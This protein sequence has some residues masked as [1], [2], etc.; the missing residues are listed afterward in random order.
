M[1]KVVAP[2][3]VFSLVSWA[4][5]AGAEA[6]IKYEN[7]VWRQDAPDPT[8]WEADGKYYAAS[9]HQDILESGDLVH[10]RKSG[11]RLLED[12]EYAWIAKTWPHV[13]APQVRKIG[14]GYNLYISFHNGGE[15]TAIAVYRSSNP[16]GPF[17]DRRILVRS[18]TDGQVE[19][20]DPEVA[21]DTDGRLWLFFGHGDVRRVELSAD[22]L[23]RKPGS[24]I[25][26]VAGIEWAS[27]GERK[28]YSP[29]CST[30]GAYLHRH[31]GKWYLFVSE[32]GWSDHTY[33]LSVG[34]ADTLD[35][36]FLDKAGRPMRDGH[37]T[38]ILQSEKNDDFFG[39]GHNGEIM[40]LPSGRT[41]VFYH[42]HWRNEQDTKDA[43]RVRS[44]SGYVPRPLFLQEIFWDADG[45]PYFENGGKPQKENV[46]RFAKTAVHPNSAALT[47]FHTGMTFGFGCPAGYFATP[48]AKAEVDHMYADGVRWV[49]LVA[50]V[51][52]EAADSPRQYAESTLTPG[53]DELAEIIA[54]MHRR[55]MRVQLRPMLECFDG[56]TRAKVQIREDAAGTDN[57]HEK[58]SAWFKGLA[59][60]SVRYAR[61]AERTGCEL[62]CIDS[63]LDLMTDCNAEWKRVIRAVREVYRGP[64]TSSHTIWVTTPD[65]LEA[66]IADKSHWFHDLDLLSLSV[67]MWTGG[68]DRTVGVEDIK[69]KLR[70]SAFSPERL[71]RWRAAY[72]KPIVFGEIGCAAQCANTF[73]VDAEYVPERQRDYMKAAFEAYLKTGAVSGFYWW[74][75]LDSLLPRETKQVDPRTAY[76][77]KGKLA[78]AE[79]KSFYEKLNAHEV[80]MK[81][82]YEPG[83]CGLYAALPDERHAWAVHDRNR[84][85]PRKVSAPEGGVPSDAIVLFDGSAKSVDENWCAQDGGKT[86]W[87]LENGAFVC[88]PGSGM[89]RTKRTFGD[90]QLHVEWFTP[91]TLK[92]TGQARGNS[93]VIFMPG[94]HEVQVLD[95]WGTDPADMTNPNYADGQAGAVY[96]QNP[97]LVN[98]A[99]PT[100]TWQTFDIVYHPP[101][102]EG[103]ALVDPGSMTC[104][105]NGVLVQDAWPLEGPTLW[106]ERTALRA[107]KDGEGYLLLQD[108]G[109]PVPYRNV[110][111]REIPSRFADAA[112]GGPGTTRKAVFAERERIAEKLFAKVDATRTTA[113]NV[114]QALEVLAYANVPKYRAAAERLLATWRTDAAAQ[115]DGEG[116]KS[117]NATLRLLKAFGIEVK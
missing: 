83:R 41:Y 38:P 62:Y 77:V 54:Y 71:K 73:S 65:K 1:M 31:A 35:G 22:G 91:T 99:R 52:S 44:K 117:V 57:R 8:V 101:R 69:A 46:L 109:N 61:L 4:Q 66:H 102:Y 107:Q 59:E 72:G 70:A 97:P 55:G 75:W 30:E 92:G 24:A 96:G 60:R 36:E 108:H 50:T 67:Y 115:K 32:G 15:H 29:A 13:W 10:W 39:P 95:S 45:W 88:V 116:V 3:L 49:C 18:E 113:E 20:I 86:K 94:W 104:F 111:V 19:V 43:A 47:E 106:R 37:A 34:R 114:T 12:A 33:R 53:D 7:P 81:A 105:F 78:E 27:R 74:E 82:K 40:T 48:A 25:E 28:Y 110:W 11:R 84:P 68:A 58:R 23:S 56:T 14:A 42:C 63:E 80:A 16:Q 85:N 9:T 90:C 51:W 112:A 103:T 79:L 98:P 87:K 2:V 64:V 21:K 6:E 100:G 26:H 17:K 93:G 89:V 76:S 5:F